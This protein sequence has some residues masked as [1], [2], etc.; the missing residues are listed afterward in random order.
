[1]SL[2][3]Y[4][5]PLPL[6]FGIA[7][8]SPLCT[9]QQIRFSQGMVDAAMSQM[10]TQIVVQNRSNQACTL[11]S[12]PQVSGVL[13]DQSLVSAQTQVGNYFVVPNNDKEAMT[14]EPQ[15]RAWFGIYASHAQD[16]CPE[17][18]SISI[19]ID[20]SSRHLIHYHGYTCSL[21]VTD[22]YPMTIQP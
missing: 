9:A 15:Q 11:P 13:A 19:A 7:V 1:M 12:Y 3:R 18:N 8:A 20:S 22:F 21:S 2:I 17:F 6:S 5:L 16:D 14:L 4:L 10:M